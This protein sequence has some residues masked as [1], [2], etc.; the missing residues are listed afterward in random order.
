MFFSRGL[1]GVNSKAQPIEFYSN[2]DP[3]LLLHGDGTDTST[4]IT[5][6]GFNS[7]TITSNNSAQID[8]AQKV[9]G[10]GSIYFINS[11]SYITAPD[12]DSWD[13]G[14]GN[15]LV[16]FRVRFNSLSNRSVLVSSGYD[17]TVVTRSWQISYDD[18]VGNL[19]LFQST[20]G[21]DNFGITPSWS[22]NTGQWYHICVSRVGSTITI[23]IDGAVLTTGTAQDLFNTSK[24]LAMGA[25]LDATEPLDGWMDEIRILK[26]VGVDSAFTV[27]T[28][29]YS[30]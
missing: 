15:W 10:T 11:N 9:F 14:S 27:P 7:L 16:D 19:E 5:D 25:S 23:F 29:A 18:S 4:T 21:A 3:D 26:G 24:S 1:I 8:T 20:T 17:S 2:R 12:N 28:E 13:F 22:P 6:S 30:F